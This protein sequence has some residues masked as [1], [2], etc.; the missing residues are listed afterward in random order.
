[1]S[2]VTALRTSQ[3]P[4]KPWQTGDVWRLV[5]CVIIGIMMGGLA[6]MAIHY[7]EI[8]ETSSPAKFLALVIAAFVSYLAAIV[9]LSRPWP[10]DPDVVRLIVLIALI[11][12]GV[13]L[14]WGASKLI[15]GDMELKNP[16][17]T[18]V[19]AVLAFQGLALLLVHFFLR[20]HLTNWIE[21]F[22]LNI[23]PGQ[24][25]LIGIGVGILVV[26]PVLL[27]NELCFHLFERLTLHPQEQ[28]AVEILR[29]AESLLGRAASGIATV[30]L[31]PIGEEVVFRGILY[32]WAKRRF[33]QPIALWGTA[34]LFG[35]IHLNLSSF[36]PLTILA[37]VLV[38]L[39]EYT[40]NLLAPIAVHVVFNGTNFIALF[41]Q[42]K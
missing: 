1:M 26:Y 35:A 7:F 3:L 32:P 29:G 9:M 11:Q 20:R 17:I 18:M 28:Q 21:G 25:I 30:F 23:H 12:G 10:E 2:F 31:A 5:G 42:Q 37:L 4:E 36:I 39:Y 27:L 8:P 16:I 33:S 19:I 15:K 40:G 6:A 14:T 24:S 13:F 34:I 22:G 41:F 38:W